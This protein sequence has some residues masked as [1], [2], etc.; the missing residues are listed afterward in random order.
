M[1]SSFYCYSTSDYCYC[2]HALWV[3]VRACMCRYWGQVYLCCSILSYVYGL[4]KVSHILFI[5]MATFYKYMYN[6]LHCINLLHIWAVM[7]Q[8]HVSGLNWM[9]LLHLSISLAICWVGTT[10]L[11]SIIVHCPILYLH[12]SPAFTTAPSILCC[13]QSWRAMES[14]L[15]YP[16]SRGTCYWH[17]QCQQPWEY[18]WC[19][20]GSSQQLLIWWTWPSLYLAEGY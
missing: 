14:L 3:Y 4:K 8:L 13:S 10:Q 11:R 7:F 9:H 2:T 20:G 5:T 17:S 16:G 1:A 6:Y 19:N 18:Q 15:P 12:Y